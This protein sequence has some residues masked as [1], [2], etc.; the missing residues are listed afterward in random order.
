MAGIIDSLK[1]RQRQ[2]AAMLNP[3]RHSGSGN[4]LL[5]KSSSLQPQT[6]FRETKAS[7]SVKRPPMTLLNLNSMAS[8]SKKAET[9]Y[10]NTE[11][12]MHLRPSSAGGTA[13]V[14]RAPAPMPLPVSG[15][16]APQPAVGESPVSA[17]SMPPSSGISTPAYPPKSERRPVVFDR[18]D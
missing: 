4:G 18:Y 13:T 8:L 16:A 14:Q 3:G 15:G 6:V 10:T 7:F 9:K 1:A 17:S 12:L 5:L 2:N 11:N